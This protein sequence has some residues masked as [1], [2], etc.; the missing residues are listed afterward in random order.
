MDVRPRMSRGGSYASVR[1]VTCVLLREI[2]T[3]ML[4]AD[5]FSGRRVAY[6]DYLGYDEVAHHAGPATDDARRTLRNM[7]G[8]VRQLESAARRAPRHYYHA[9]RSAVL[10]SLDCDGRR[11]HPRSP[12]DGPTKA[13]LGANGQ[14]VLQSDNQQDPYQR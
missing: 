10:D 7:E 11:R 2:T 14:A 6:A 13:A 9:R 12:A 5:M 3:W 8:Q 4:V 1:A